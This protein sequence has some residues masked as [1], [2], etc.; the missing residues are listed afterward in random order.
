MVRQ[1]EGKGFR[2]AEGTSAVDAGNLLETVVTSPYAHSG[3]TR[4]EERLSD[5]AA[6]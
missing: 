2:A 5:E 4:D 1:E 3:A 6:S